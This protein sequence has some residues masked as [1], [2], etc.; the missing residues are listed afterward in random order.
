M[1]AWARLT[2]QA[3]DP[4]ALA[5]DLERR[6]GRG[7][8]VRRGLGGERVIRMDGGD[9]HIVPWRVEAADDTP[10]PEGRLLFE[11]VNPGGDGLAV[12]DDA[13][14]GPA[15]VLLAAPPFRLAG[16]GWATV[17]LD[18]SSAELDPWLEPTLDGLDGPD[19]HDP[20]LGALTRVRR[21][22]GLPGE[23]LVLAEPVTE[24][25]LAAAL[26]RDGEGPCVLYLEPADGLGAWRAGAASRGITTSAI[27]PGPLGPSVLVSGTRSGPHLVVIEGPDGSSPGAHGGTIDP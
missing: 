15:E 25:R 8:A 4:A 2:W 12:A 7:A 20:H 11:P 19:G 27:R 9:V 21:S 6:L 5:A 13:E 17:E 16:V 1:T 10:R 22:P 26:A 18:R 24:G 23:A 14:R 3:K